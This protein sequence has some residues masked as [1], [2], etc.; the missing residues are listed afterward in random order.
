M[1]AFS[2]KLVGEYIV[3]PFLKGNSSVH[4]KCC[5]S[6]H[7]LGSN[8]SS[9]VRHPVGLSLHR[10]QRFIHKTARML[11][12]TANSWKSQLHNRD[13]SAIMVPRK[14]RMLCSN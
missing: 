14:D 1:D 11:P 10:V 5:I 4:T 7:A 6:G 9:A 12:A 13:S 3:M 8:D 2:E